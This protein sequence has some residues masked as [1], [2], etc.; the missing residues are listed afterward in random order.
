MKK[1]YSYNKFISESVK[2]LMT[3]KPEMEGLESFKKKSK[4]EMADTLYGEC[5]MLFATEYIFT[6]NVP[7]INDEFCNFIQNE[8]GF[9]LWGQLDKKYKQFIT[10]DV[11]LESLSKEELIKAYK[12]IFDKL[13]K[14]INE[15]VSDM[16]TPKSKEDI[17][18]DLK[19]LDPDKK[20]LVG[21]EY[22]LLWLV[23][24]GLEE[25][26]K[27]TGDAGY[28]LMD[29]AKV[30]D[31]KDIIQLLVDKGVDPGVDIDIIKHVI[32]NRKVDESVRDLMKPK[33]EDELLSDKSPNELLHGSIKNKWLPGVEAAIVK[34]ADVNEP[35]SKG[36]TPLYNSVINHFLEGVQLLLAFD[37]NIDARN[38]FGE[39]AFYNAVYFGNFKIIKEL[40]KHNPNPNIKNGW[41]DD[42]LDAIDV[43]GDHYSDEHEEMEKIVTDYVNKYN[44][45]NESVKDLMTP[46]SKEEIEEHIPKE[47][48]LVYNQIPYEKEYTFSTMIG[49]EVTLR[50][51]LK[52]RNVSVFWLDNF[53]FYVVNVW[54]K[55][56]NNLHSYNLTN[57]DVVISII[58]DNAE[59]NESVRDLMTPKS[60][61]DIM[62]SFNKFHPLD[63]VVKGMNQGELFMV[64]KGVQILSSKCKPG[65]M[66]EIL[67]NNLRNF[68]FTIAVEKGYMDIVKYV[69]EVGFKP[70]KDNMTWVATNGSI[71]M[72]K[73]LIEYG[74]VVDDELIEHVTKYRSDNKEEVLQLL[75]HY[76]KD[77]VINKIKKRW[78]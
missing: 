63:M 3:P 43:P 53:H 56:M 58:N 59:V 28:L 68:Y 21:Y 55:K 69:L 37:A 77:K 7:I 5:I 6:T 40:I 25:G 62:K 67:Q 12:L 18:N 33:G 70:N 11:V 66:A 64:K 57:I 65:E 42:L 31:R 1:L 26:G 39:T 50:I 52:H 41:K 36:N 20:L 74:V 34:G 45:T 9:D 49:Q 48:K 4:E 19:K 30:N 32:P 76:N 72:I 14:D 78:F 71:D 22:E 44:K 23:K 61:E 46:K 10:I 24:L 47:L 35:D 8:V 16:M 54:D 29:F 75:N 38:N 13:K 27:F 73:L 15:G 2:D 60:E 51:S 17:V